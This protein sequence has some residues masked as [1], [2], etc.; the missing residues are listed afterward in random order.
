MKC[1]ICHS[2]D[3]EEKTVNETFW[4]E[5]D[6]V[7]APCRVLVCNN[8]GERYYNR[9]VMRHLE[10][11]EMHLQSKTLTLETVGQVLKL[12]AQPELALST[13]EPA[14]DY[15]TEGPE[16]SDTIPHEIQMDD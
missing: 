6:L 9:Q 13:C 11:I 2:S 3:I 10:E 5:K 12:T 16:S 4:V 15:D 1:V 8:C 14:P 7:L